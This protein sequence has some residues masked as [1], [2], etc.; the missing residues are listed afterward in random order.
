MNA[1]ILAAGLG[2]RLRPLTDARP[3]ALVEV[4]GAS[5][6]QHLILK[7]KCAGFTHIVVNVHYMSE[8]II[9]FLQRNDSF[10]I[11]I[12]VS[13]ER[14]LLLDT[15]G[16][17][18]RALSFFDDEKP[19]LVHNVDVISDVNLGELYA[20]AEGCDTLLLVQKRSSSR[21][22]FFDEQMALAGWMNMKSGE[23][24]SPFHDFAPENFTPYAFSGIHVINDAMAR[25]MK[26]TDGA[27]P[28]IPFYLENAARMSV[29]AALFPDTCRWVDAGTPEALERAAD[30]LK[31]TNLNK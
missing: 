9:D 2:T 13:D 7:M 11:R 6:L 14:N 3:K 5:M 29:K 8:Q 19:V 15:G 22:L 16:G 31:N 20:S 28:L 21:M 25:R 4:A 27:F 24:R 23:K 17:I 30:I 10:G 26:E 1:I 12:D 18:A